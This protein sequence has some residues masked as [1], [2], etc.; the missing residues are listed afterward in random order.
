MDRVLAPGA[1]WAAPSAISGSGRRPR[2]RRANVA[3]ASRFTRV[4]PARKHLACHVE[5]TAR[6]LTVHAHAQIGARQH[7]GHRR[8]GWR[9]GR[10]AARSIKRLY[11]VS[12]SVAFWSIHSAAVVA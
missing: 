6:R 10:R 7:R 5:H 12:E 11:S 9:L 2:W 1:V 8:D 3:P 4:T